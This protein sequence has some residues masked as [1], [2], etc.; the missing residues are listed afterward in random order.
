LVIVS[1]ICASLGFGC[2]AS[3]AAADMI[4]PVWQ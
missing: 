4:M 2:F 3:K 1:S